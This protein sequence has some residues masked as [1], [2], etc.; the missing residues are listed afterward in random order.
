MVK[1]IIYFLWKL[2]IRT[3]LCEKIKH[4]K[5]FFFLLTFLLVSCVTTRVKIVDGDV[6]ESQKI[7]RF[8][9]KTDTVYYRTLSNGEIVTEKEYDKRWER[10]V[11]RAMKKIE[12]QNKN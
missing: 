5:Y 10:A 6:V 4:M 7:F 12:K 3:Y 8:T 2:K 9:Q 11:D 1:K